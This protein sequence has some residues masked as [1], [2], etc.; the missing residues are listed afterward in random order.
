M[1]GFLWLRCWLLLFFGLLLGLSLDF[2]GGD[3]LVDSLDRGSSVS[4]IARLSQLSIIGLSWSCFVL[5]CGLW[6]A[7]G[8]SGGWRCFVG[9]WL[10]SGFIGLSI[11]LF[12]W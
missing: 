10:L 7:L 8:G 11:L 12:R 6:L 5:L 4:L 9:W 3:R 1:S 2:S